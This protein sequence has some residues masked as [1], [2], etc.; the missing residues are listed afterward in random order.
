MYESFI[1]ASMRHVGINGVT[2]YHISGSLKK[3]GAKHPIPN[4]GETTH[5][6]DRLVH[7]LSNVTSFGTQMYTLFF[8]LSP[9]TFAM[10]IHELQ[11]GI[12]TE[13][14]L[15]NNWAAATEL[16]AQLHAVVRS[17]LKHSS[18]NFPLNKLESNSVQT[19]FELLVRYAPT[20]SEANRYY[21]ILLKEYYPPIRDDK[22]VNFC[23][24]SLIYKYAKSFEEE[25]WEKGLGLVQ[26]ALD[27][28]LGLPT[29]VGMQSNTNKG[30]GQVQGAPRE[31]ANRNQKG[32]L[33]NVSKEILMYNGLRIAQDGSELERDPREKRS[34]RRPSRVNHVP[35]APTAS[36]SVKP[37]TPKINS[38]GTVIGKGKEPYRNKPAGGSLDGDLWHEMWQQTM[39]DA[40]SGN[41]NH[42][43]ME[44]AEPNRVIE[45]E[46]NGPGFHSKQQTHLNNQEPDRTLVGPMLSLASSSSTQSSES[47]SSK[48]RHNGGRNAKVQ[49]R[50]SS[51]VGS[52]PSASSVTMALTKAAPT[53]S[54]SL[55]TPSSFDKS[56]QLQSEMA[57]DP[58]E[59]LLNSM[60]EMDILGAE[61]TERGDGGSVV[62]THVSVEE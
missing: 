47:S 44:N 48:G 3:S 41:K 32:I 30:D 9:S 52:S 46:A 11:K 29:Y 31:S 61:K 43:V 27:R 6:D 21:L 55:P 38:G 8:A 22:C 36:G 33:A 56:M 28:G 4:L 35:D 37:V 20:V 42:V 26:V 51:S 49:K 12:L 23:L 24:I 54:A 40:Q 7:V 17:R 14:K 57:E 15:N 39:R 1:Y 58:D 62:G 25:Y 53:V 2:N 50:I 59:V 18:Q 19:A 34:L 5:D 45:I 60:Q 13:A 16:F 10:S